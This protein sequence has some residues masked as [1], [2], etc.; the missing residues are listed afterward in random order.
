[1]NIEKINSSEILKKLDLKKDGYFCVSFHR[2]KHR[3]KKFNSI[4]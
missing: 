1:M 4:Y 2:E 3:I